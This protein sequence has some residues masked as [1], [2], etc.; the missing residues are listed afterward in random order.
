MSTTGIIYKYTS[1]SNKV[2]IGRTINE[3]SR[4]NQHRT[5][6]VKQ[7]KSAFG[8]AIKKYGFDNFEYE[9]IVKF[10]DVVDK[11]KLSRVL[12]KLEIRYI[13]MYDSHNKDFGYN[14]T[15]G[16]EG[17]SG[18]IWTEEMRQES[19]Q[20]AVEK[21]LS[22]TVYQFSK[23]KIFIQ[24]FPSIN[25]AA[26]SLKGNTPLISKRISEVCNNKWESAYNY[27]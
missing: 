19:I 6:T 14:L 13:K 26:E 8:N 20:N 7:K 22:K 16:G 4:K 23:D 1:P 18:V 27:I 17:G 12:N 21:G 5:Q 25:Q 2:Y 15:L 9:V 24:S 10:K 11:D 3:R